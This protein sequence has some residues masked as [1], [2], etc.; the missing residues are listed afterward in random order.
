MKI[1]ISDLEKNVIP[2]EL[3][4]EESTQAFSP[5]IELEKPARVKCSLSF[6]DGT[7][8]LDCDVAAEIRLSCTRCL[9]AYVLK[10]RRIFSA[11]YCGRRSRRDGVVELESGELDEDILPASGIIDL[12]DL[13]RQQLLLGMSMKHI[14]RDD[15]KGLC[16]RCGANLNKETCSC[17]LSQ[18]QRVKESK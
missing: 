9:E 14:C 6:S 3:D 7:I 13:I 18:S 11:R 8:G 1:S 12:T 4:Y 10:A 16:S 2:K 5:E 15:C 17:V